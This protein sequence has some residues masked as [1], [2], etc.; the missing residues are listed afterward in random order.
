LLFT[1]VTAT[2]ANPPTTCLV[3]SF[4]ADSFFSCPVSLILVAHEKI[5]HFWRQQPVVATMVVELTTIII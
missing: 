1:T 3:N 4:A 2:T 5:K